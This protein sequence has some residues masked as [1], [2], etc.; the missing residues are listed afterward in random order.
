MT[1]DEF[2]YMSGEDPEDVFGLDWENVIEEL[3]TKEKQTD[4]NCE[5]DCHKI[6][7]RDR[8]GGEHKCD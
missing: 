6:I 2:I 4:P 3:K 7:D 8:F 1:K 5:C